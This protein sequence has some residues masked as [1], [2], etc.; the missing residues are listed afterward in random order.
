M[1]IV[2]SQ[3]YKAK[4]K[5]DLSGVFYAIK[6]IK[7]EFLK[8]EPRKLLSPN[9]FICQ[10]LY[11]LLI[12]ERYYLIFDFLSISF[13]YVL[14]EVKTFSEKNTRVYLA[15]I[16]LAIT[17]LHKH[18][19]VYRDLTPDKIFLQD[20]GTKLRKIFNIHKSQLVLKF[21]NFKSGHIKIIRK[22]EKIERLDESMSSEKCQYLAPEIL[23]AEENQFFGAEDFWALG[24]LAFLF[25][26]GNNPFFAKTLEEVTQKILCFCEMP[27]NQFS[28]AA[29]S[30]ISQVKRND[31][32]FLHTQFH[33]SFQLLNSDPQE[34]HHFATQSL[35]THPFFDQ[36]NLDTLLT[37]P[38]DLKPRDITK[39]KTMTAS[40]ENLP[41]SAPKDLDLI[42]FTFAKQKASNENK[43]SN[44]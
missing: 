29:Q 35:K 24:V 30:F 40:N 26:S 10:L 20:N 31:F 18:G 9:P 12:E 16:F 42:G 25:L 23:M 6:V 33:S 8:T 27:T 4:R 36:L 32:N 37:L 2:D 41:M 15:E 38:M 44:G 39:P 13:T 1:E 7:K 5:G 11:Q 34:R 43:T 28:S 17:C 21:S 19:T 22:F 3:V 14:K